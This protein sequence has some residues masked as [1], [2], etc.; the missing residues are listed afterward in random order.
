[1]QRA[2]VPE[3]EDGLP[4][5]LDEQVELRRH[6]A[7]RVPLDGASGH[8]GAEGEGDGEREKGD[9]HDGGEEPRPQRRKPMSLHGLIAL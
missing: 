9:E 1:M 8:E 2:Q 7:Q 6:V 4:L 5:T 3:G